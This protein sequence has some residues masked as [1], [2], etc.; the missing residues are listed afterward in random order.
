MNEG[1]LECGSC[2]R[3]GGVQLVEA[4]VLVTGSV[5]VGGW[6]GAP[7][8]DSLAATQLPS[9]SIALCLLVNEHMLLLRMSH[10]SLLG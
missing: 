7:Q 10:A 4:V 1:L 6:C 8:S 5:R 9:V 3:Q 2:L